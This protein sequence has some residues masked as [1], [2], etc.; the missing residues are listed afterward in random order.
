[1]ARQSI[2]LAP[3]LPAGHMVLADIF[4]QQL[5][6]GSAAVEFR[7]GHSLAGGDV[8]DLITY[9]HFLWVLGDQNEAIDVA[10]QAQA[11]DP[12]NPRAFSLEGAVLLHAARYSDGIAAYRKALALAPGRLGDRALLAM[13]LLES[14]KEDQARAELQKL[15]PDY[16]F[17]LFAEAVMF[18]H[19]GKRAESDAAMHRF[20]Q[21]NGDAA[22]YQ[23]ADI[24]AQRGEKDE[25][26]AA[27]DRAWTFRDPGLAL[28]RSDRFLDP[29][30]GDPRFAALLQ[31]MN[32]PA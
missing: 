20:Q 7:K 9:G 31:K 12:L 23:Y 11:S 25:A 32:F 15:P 29:L 24:H 16:I 19:D 18:A 30:R 4:V 26:F 22:N 1:V 13:G 28:L 3:S 8:D 5:D 6:I 27:L 17:R 21:L 2:S 14:G 10:R